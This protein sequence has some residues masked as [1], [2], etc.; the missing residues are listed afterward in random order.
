MSSNTLYISLA[1]F[2]VYLL[3]SAGILFIKNILRNEKKITNLL[4]TVLMSSFIG[5]IALLTF[6]LMK[7]S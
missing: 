5:G 1:V 2:S 7:M 3:F 6:S 4:L